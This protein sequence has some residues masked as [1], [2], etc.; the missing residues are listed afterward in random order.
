MTALRSALDAGSAGYASNRD[1]MLARLAEIEAEHAKAVGGSPR[2][3]ARHRARGKIA[4]RDRID[5]LLDAGSPFLELSP[6]AAFGLYNG[7]LPAAGIVRTH[8]DT[9]CPNT[10]QCT[11]CFLPMPAPVTPPE[12]TW[13]VDSG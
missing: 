8:A 6:L 7:E 9:I 13:V 3:A 1:S 5:L 10:F 2:H 12:T 11:G 4:V